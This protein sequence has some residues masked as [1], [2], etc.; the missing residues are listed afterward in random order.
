MTAGVANKLGIG[1]D[2][3]QAREPRRRLLQ[4][5]GVRARRAR[6]RTSAGSTRCTR[7]RPGSSTRPARR[8]PATRRSTTASGCATRPTRCSRS[9]AA[10]PRCTT[11]AAPARARSCGRRCSTAARCS[12]PTRCSSTA[13][14][15][16]APG[17]TRA[18]TASTPC[19]RLYET[20]DGWIQ[21]AAVKE[22]EWVALCGV[23]GVPEL[24][25]DA[26]FAV[27]DLRQEH[28][29]ELEALLAR[30]LRDA[31]RRSCG[32]ARS[33]T[34]ACPNEIPVDTKAGDLVLFDAD[35]E[36]LGLVAE[37]EHPIMG[38][39]R[40]F[41]ELIQFSDTPAHVARP[42]AARRREH[43]RDPRR[44]SATTTPRSTRCS[45]TTSSTGPSPTTPGSI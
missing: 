45:R 42:A 40:Q 6:S 32:A 20:Q 22:S 21:I 1:Y 7:P 5:V 17:S 12:R 37:Y 19:Y 18:C 27:A 30:A 15:C 14:R 34:P 36:R 41:G 44:G 2:G 43:P 9:S 29:A 39:L 31:R 10:W 8:T 26:R 35:N 33:T 38:T 23:L 4:H 24:A 28:R 13:R 3:L 25:D 11:S 16:P